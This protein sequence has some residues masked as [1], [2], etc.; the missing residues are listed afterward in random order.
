MTDRKET[1]NDLYAIISR[2]RAPD[3]C[4]WD[5]KQTMED[6]KKYLLEESYETVTAVQ[7]NDKES[8]KE[9][10]GDVFL[11]LSMMMRIAEENG[12]FYP[13]D[14]FNEIC[15]KL[16]RRHPHVFGEE[17]ID[18]PEKV[19][20]KWDEI[21]TTLEGRKKKKGV[22]AVSPGFPPLE[23]SYKIQKRAAKEGFDWEDHNGPFRKIE[24][25]LEELKNAIE[26]RKNS[27]TEEELGDLLFSVVN[28]A[29][30]LNVDP[31]TALHRT[32]QKFLARYSEVERLMKENSLEMKQENLEIMDRYWNQAK[33]LEQNPDVQT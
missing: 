22:H 31:M 21:K 12:D 18:D 8:I 27:D 19:K 5:R 14:V 2:L 10:I 29:R 30:K 4:P 32:N 15:R 28:I 13:G 3:G 7:E 6:M 9:E 1:F 24:E 11:I 17:E 16:V 25:E 33:K 26:K 23:R 20:E